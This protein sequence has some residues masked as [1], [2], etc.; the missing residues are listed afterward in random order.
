MQAKVLQAQSISLEGLFYSGKCYTGFT[1]SRL[2]FTRIYGGG[3]VSGDKSNN[4]FYNPAGLINAS[5][6]N[7]GQGIVYVAINY[8]LGALGWL[9]GPSFQQQ[10]GISNAALY[11]QRLA[12]EWVKDNIHLFGGDPGQITLIGESAGAG[13]IVHQITA[14]GGQRDISFQ[15][16]IPQSPVSI[17]ISDQ[18]TQENNTMNFFHNLNATSLDDARAASTTDVI[19]ANRHTVYT[20]TYGQYTLSPVVDSIFV[21]D[22][23]ELLLLTGTA[24][25]QNISIMI[26]H[27]TNEGP[28]LTPSYVQDDSSL[29][30]YLKYRYPTVNDATISYIIDNL[31]PAV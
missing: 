14:F 21:P 1:R 11:D 28:L 4:G 13:S 6:A 17:C 18:F 5:F 26:G 19:Q 29:A 24:Y 12:I 25:A 15:R 9:A 3:Y 10:G 23:P 27:N 2:I 20:S 31:Y 22:R 7:G 30:A 16:A 8:R